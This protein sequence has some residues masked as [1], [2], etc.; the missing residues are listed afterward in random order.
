MSKN[1]MSWISVG[2]AFLKLPNACQKILED[3]NAIIGTPCPTR[4]KQKKNL[5][6]KISHSF[7][8]GMHIDVLVLPYRY[9]AA[10]VD[11]V[12]IK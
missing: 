7:L 9:F 5:V 1:E 4:S 11:R 3:P 8:V 2:S 6:I 12:K 10:A